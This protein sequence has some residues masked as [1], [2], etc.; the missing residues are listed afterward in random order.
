MIWKIVYA[1]GMAQYVKL[2]K[3]GLIPGRGKRFLC[4]PIT[5]RQVLSPI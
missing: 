4:S 3:Q 5:F 1:A 2:E